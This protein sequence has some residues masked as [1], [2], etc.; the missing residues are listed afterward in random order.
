MPQCNLMN[1][2]LSYCARYQRN[3]L[4]A[5]EV[6]WAILGTWVIIG[7]FTLCVYFIL[8][9]IDSVS[10]ANAISYVI[11]LFKLHVLIKSTETCTNF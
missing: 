8:A 7:T 5:G 11:S 3:T 2:L 1:T 6:E 4:F 9:L 10:Y